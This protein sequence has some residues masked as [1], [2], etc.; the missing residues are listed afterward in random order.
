VVG[1][2]GRAP[3]LRPLPL[4]D[5]GLR[6]VGALPVTDLAASAAWYERLLGV[7]PVIDEDTGTFRHIVYPLPG[8]MLISLHDNRKARAG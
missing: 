7:R 3:R 1:D 5:A 8:G 2:P 4:G 6:P